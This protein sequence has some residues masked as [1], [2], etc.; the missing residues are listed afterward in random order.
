[1]P[2]MEEDDPQVRKTVTLPES[3]WRD[4]KAYR[5]QERVA[6]DTEAV[7]RLMLFALRRAIKAAERDGRKETKP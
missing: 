5:R 4:V 1:M 3:V 7:R 6:T 2:G